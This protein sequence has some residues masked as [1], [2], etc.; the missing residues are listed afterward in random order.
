MSMTRGVLAPFPAAPADMT[1]LHSC[2]RPL[3]QSCTA[4]YDRSDVDR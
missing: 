4:R 1:L 2:F 3:F